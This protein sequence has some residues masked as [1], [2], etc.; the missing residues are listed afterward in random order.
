MLDLM[1]AEE[2]KYMVVIIPPVPGQREVGRK[3]LSGPQQRLRDL[4]QKRAAKS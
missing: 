4:S 3:G 1:A 2:S